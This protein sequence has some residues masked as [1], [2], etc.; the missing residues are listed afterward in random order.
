[1]SLVCYNI[2]EAL[3]P[4][5]SRK[6]AIRARAEWICSEVAASGLFRLLTLPDDSRLTSVARSTP[7]SF[8]QP[9]TR[10][11]VPGTVAHATG[12]SCVHTGG[13]KAAPER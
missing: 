3:I 13:C 1:M 2:R 10:Q 9:A 12:S 8:L 5:S 4:A 6:P 7:I 11:A